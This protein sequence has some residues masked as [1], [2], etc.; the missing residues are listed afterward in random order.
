[1]YAL[2][3][4]HGSTEVVGHGN[5]LLEIAINPQDAIVVDATYYDQSPSYDLTD[6]AISPFAKKYWASAIPLQDFLRLSPLEQIKRFINPEIL[7]KKDT[8][9]ERIKVINVE[10]HKIKGD[11]ITLF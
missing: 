1:M 7:I 8:P 10:Q 11:S 4:Y 3:D 2:P 9:P 5:V 6:E